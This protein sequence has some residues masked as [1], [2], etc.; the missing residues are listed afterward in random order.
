M[1]VVERWALIMREISSSENGSCAYK[2]MY[3]TWEKKVKGFYTHRLR[4]AAECK[5]V[6][7]M[8]GNLLLC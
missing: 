5:G 7:S 1:S 3:Q 4:F 8:I 2:L 6:V